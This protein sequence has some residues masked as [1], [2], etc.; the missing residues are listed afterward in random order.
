MR[1]RGAS[2]QAALRGARTASQA[3]GDVRG[4]GYFIG[5]E[6]VQDRL[7]KVP[8]PQ[9]RGLESGNC[10]PR[11]CRR[12]DLLSVCRQRGRRIGRYLI[13]VRLPSTPARPSYPNSST[14]SRAP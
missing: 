7:S 10:Q 5:I 1:V 12:V 11:V 14:D 8:F 4:R 13:I 2:L 9:E 3:V 6:F